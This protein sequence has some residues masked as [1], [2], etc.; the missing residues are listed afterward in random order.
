MLLLYDAS[1]LVFCYFFGM[2]NLAFKMAQ[3]DCTQVDCALFHWRSHVHDASER[4]SLLHAMAHAALDGRPELLKDWR[5]WMMLDFSQTSYSLLLLPYALL[6]LRPL[7]KYLAVS[8]GTRA[9]GYDA[10]GCLCV[11]LTPREQSE[12]VQLLACEAT[13]AAR[14]QARVRGKRSRQ[15]AV[16]AQGML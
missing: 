4:L 14:I 6:S 8:R 9:T 1:A 3:V 2:L 12:R 5:L 11:A 16:V 15:S 13:A 7:T 10:C